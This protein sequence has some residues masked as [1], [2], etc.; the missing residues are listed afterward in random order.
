[1]MN[2]TMLAQVSGGNGFFAAL[3]QSGGSR[4]GA[5]RVYGIADTAYKNGDEMFALMHTMR[6]RTMT[7]P[8][9]TSPK[10]IA[11]IFFERA[12]DGEAE[13]RPVPAHLWQE[14]NKAIRIRPR[15]STKQIWHRH[16]REFNGS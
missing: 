7:A 1:M 14:R 5:L 4:P 10:I 6:V 8:A 9:F 12:M 3:D 2:E 16:D 15:L 11:A 13:Q